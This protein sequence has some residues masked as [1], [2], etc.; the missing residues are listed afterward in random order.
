MPGQQIAPSQRVHC[1][2]GS[3]EKVS[4]HRTRYIPVHC[5]TGSLESPRQLFHRQVYV[6]C[7]TGSLENTISR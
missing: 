6:H 5:R 3:L 4:P 7:R 1:R 2:T